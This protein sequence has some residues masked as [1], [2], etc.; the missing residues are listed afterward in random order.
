MYVMSLLLVLTRSFTCTR[1]A[2]D[3]VRIAGDTPCRDV[4]ART[5]KHRDTHRSLRVP[6]AN[7]TDGQ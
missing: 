4:F 5:A 6:I 3:G 1:H 7:G 2:A